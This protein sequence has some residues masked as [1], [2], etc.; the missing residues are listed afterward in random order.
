MALV[1][2]MCSQ[3]DSAAVGTDSAKRYLLEG[4]LWFYRDVVCSHCYMARNGV[5]KVLV[6]NGCCC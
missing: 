4:S 6:R 5:Y 3:L 2:C 1:G